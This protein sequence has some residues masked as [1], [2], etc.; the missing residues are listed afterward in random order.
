M[1]WEQMDITRM[2]KISDA[3]IDIVLDKGTLDALNEND[4]LQGKAMKESFRVLRPGGHLLSLTF[5]H[6]RVEDLRKHASNVE[7]VSEDLKYP[8]LAKGKA[9]R[10]FTFAA[11]RKPTTV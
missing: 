9:E 4:E 6:L 11:C 1:T 8:A 7:C 2:D 10:A 3:T 5:V